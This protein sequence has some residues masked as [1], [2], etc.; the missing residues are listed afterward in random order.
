MIK[1][2]KIQRN[3]LIFFCFFSLY[4]FFRY[5]HP[6]VPWDGDD[7]RTLGEFF[8][9]YVKN[10]LPGPGMA[11][12]SYCSLL[13]T[14]SGYVAAFI[15][16]PI[17]HDYLNSF[18]AVGAFLRSIS[19]LIV[20][21]G[22]YKLLM[23]LFKKHEIALLGS[24]FFLAVSFM[25]FKTT[26]QSIYLFCTYNYC[27]IFYYTVPSCLA[28]AFA[29]YLINLEI[30]NIIWG[31]DIK[32]GLLFVILY[33]LMFSFFPAALLITIIS[34]CILVFNIISIRNIK[35]IIRR[36]YFY[37]IALIFF[38]L[39]FFFEFSRTFGSGYFH[40]PTEISN[41]F[42]A[43]FAVLF[44]SFISMNKLVLFFSVFILLFSIYSYLIK[45]KAGEAEKDFIYVLKIIS[46]SFLLCGVY[47]ILMGVVSL[48]HLSGWGALTCRID[49]LF[50]FYFLFLILVTICLAFILHKYY[51]LVIAVPL[52]VFIVTCV[53]INPSCS[54][55]DS[56]YND[57]TPNQRYT[58][59]NNIVMEAQVRDS[60]G[61]SSMIVHIPHYGHYGGGMGYVMYIHNITNS[62]MNIEFVYDENVKNIGDMYFE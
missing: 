33:F 6:M 12:H 10:G 5:V 20:I 40:T 15:I 22:I 50:V 23:D 49:T 21:I 59:M 39:K 17:T 13:G 37:I 60:N 36:S 31:F 14:I 61:V 58:I 51:N 32:T 44:G 26:E 35:I 62:I 19:A 48:G 42:K 27:T 53:S 45:K 52:F 34:F 16:Y 24:M 9:A 38:L 57:T 1:S 3:I 28:S 25:L 2:I 56:T 18:I 41:Q 54:Y 29:V 11:S 55:S 30:N 4:I 7:W 8:K 46:I 43:S 47:F